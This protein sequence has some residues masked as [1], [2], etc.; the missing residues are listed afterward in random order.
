MKTLSSMTSDERV[1]RWVHQHTR[2]VL[3]ATSDEKVAESAKW[4]IANLI[5][6]IKESQEAALNYFQSL[7][8]PPD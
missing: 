2:K 6:E 4:L 8:N 1:E 3:R 5:Q 7:F